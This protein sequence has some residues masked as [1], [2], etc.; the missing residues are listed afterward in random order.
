M[1]FIIKWADD[2]MGEHYQITDMQLQMVVRNPATGDIAVYDTDGISVHRVSVLNSKTFA[3]RY[4]K[5]FTDSVTSISF[6][7]KGTYLIVGTASVN[8]TYI[9]SWA[10][11][12]V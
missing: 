1:L 12:C 4:T 8:G 6:S 7:E 9:V 5:R 10:R 3:R 11:R 2:G